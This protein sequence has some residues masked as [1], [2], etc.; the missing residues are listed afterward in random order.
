ME[1]TACRRVH[2]TWDLPFQKD[3]MP[4]PRRVRIR[5]RLRRQ[6]GFGIRVQRMPVYVVRPSGFHHVSQIHDADPVADMFHHA[7]VMG[8]KQVADS[9]PLLDILEKIDHLRLDR[10]I[11]RRDR[12]VADDKIRLQR[13]RPCNAD[14]L[15][16][17]TGKLM[18]ISA[19]MVRLQTDSLQQLLHPLPSL[20]RRIHM[21]NHHRLLDNLPY[22]KSGIQR[23]VGILENH[24]EFS[25]VSMHLFP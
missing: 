19:D 20:F 9:L 13:Q 11:Q 15:S 17:A 1:R 6:Q 10:H 12:L 24:L 23:R 25:P 3:P 5:N 4:R 8:N 7:Q 14:P 21:V 18:G 22:R 16:L 2:R